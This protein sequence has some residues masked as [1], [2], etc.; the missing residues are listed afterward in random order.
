MNMEIDI[1]A[2]QNFGKAALQKMGT[3]SKNFRL[4]KAEWLEDDTDREVMKVTGAVFRVAKSGINK[5][6]LSILVKGTEKVVF[7]TTEEMNH[8][9]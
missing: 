2:E 6:K 5:D 4:Y 3:I 1:F 9:M 7:I 8:N